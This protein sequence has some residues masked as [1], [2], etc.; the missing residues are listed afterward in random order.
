MVAMEV[1]ID[2]AELGA[3][4]PLERQRGHLDHRDLASLLAGG[5]GDL[6]ADP[7]GPDDHQP[8]TVLD[9]LADQLGIADG[10][11]VVDAVEIGAGHVEAPWHAAGGQEEAVVAQAPV[12]FEQELAHAEVDARHPGRGQKVD[13]MLGVERVRVDVRLVADLPAQVLLGERRALV[14]PLGLV[15]D[16][17]QLTVESLLAQRLCRLGSG[18]AGAD[19]HESLA[20]GHVAP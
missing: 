10:P 11:Q 3:E 4:D 19:D 9:P 18:Q 15:A 17:H 8:L 6:G 16:Q 1:E 2:P 20:V 14:G 5:R 7:A 12:S 13:L